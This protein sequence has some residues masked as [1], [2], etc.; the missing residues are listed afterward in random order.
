MEKEA[1]I[2]GSPLCLRG[3][4]DKRTEKGGVMT[5]MVKDLVDIE[6]TVIRKEVM[7]TRL[8]LSG[9]V[10]G[11][12]GSGMRR[13]VDAAVELS[14]IEFETHASLVHFLDIGAVDVQLQIDAQ[15]SAG[16]SNPNMEPPCH[17]ANR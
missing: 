11:R 7:R 5:A 6:E 1:P 14:A 12:G 4:L 10:V 3:K 2:L 13:G 8:G 16:V 15:E 9:A 17:T